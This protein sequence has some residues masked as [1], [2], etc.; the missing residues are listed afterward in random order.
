M[1]VAFACA[2]DVA[3]VRCDGSG[4]LPH[5]AFRADG[6]IDETKSGD[7]IGKFRQETG[8]Q[9]MIAE[10][11]SLTKEGQTRIQNAALAVLLGGGGTGQLLQ[12]IRNLWGQAPHFTF[13][14]KS[15]LTSL[16][17]LSPQVIWRGEQADWRTREKI[18]GQSPHLCP[19][20]GTG[21]DERSNWTGDG[22]H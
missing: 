6:R 18:R 8:A 21:A 13:P 2:A 10:D 3:D 22:V 1:I 16:Q 20:G 4:L 17:C 11:S 9:G 5:M 7:A 12:K 15:L 14:Y 19:C